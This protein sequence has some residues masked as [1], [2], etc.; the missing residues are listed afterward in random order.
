MKCRF[1]IIPGGS[2]SRTL[3]TSPE[4]I[5]HGYNAPCNSDTIYLPLPIKSQLAVR[6][7]VR[8]VRRTICFARRKSRARSSFVIDMPAVFYLRWLGSLACGKDFFSRRFSWKAEKR[9]RRFLL[10]H[11]VYSKF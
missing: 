4:N 7:L 5:M 3:N 11:I 10:L 2:T 6:Y 9:L 1:L 8:A